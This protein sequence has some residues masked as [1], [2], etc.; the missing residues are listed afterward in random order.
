M[1]YLVILLFVTFLALSYDFTIRIKRGLN[2]SNRQ[3]KYSFVIVGLLISLI[4]G[5]R[6]YVGADTANYVNDYKGMPS[7][8]TFEQ[9]SYAFSRYRP[10]YV[11]LVAFSKSIWNNFVFLQLIVAFFAN[12]VLLLFVWRETK[13]R[14]V[15]LLMYLILNYIEYNF[16]IMREVMAVSCVLVGYMKYEKKKKWQA[17]IWFIMANLM[18]ASAIVA[19]LFPF[20]NKIK[21][22]TRSLILA[23]FICASITSVYQLVPDF[24]LYVDLV[25][26]YG[27]YAEKY[28][29]REINQDYNIHF[30]FFHY[31][32]YLIIPA[33]ALWITKGRYKYTGFVY[34]WMLW[35]VM[36]IFS[37][38]FYRFNNYFSPFYWLLLANTIIIISEK[39]IISKMV[40]VLGSVIFLLYMYQR[41]LLSVD[42]YHGGYKIYE[43]Y[44]PYEMVGFDHDYNTDKSLYPCRRGN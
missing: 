14:F 11:L 4:A 16:E 9:Y 19:A 32:K 1:I 40:L 21:F 35:G 31:L 8:G 38:S 41:T 13:F 33:L 27:D 34:M 30:Y 43:R 26:G 3:Y 39:K 7:F 42:D 10:G 37:Y 18:H 23:I 15:A 36:S 29:S 24:S 22:S 28:L 2:V 25:F 17:F 20:L 6:F 12:T 44:I 5:L